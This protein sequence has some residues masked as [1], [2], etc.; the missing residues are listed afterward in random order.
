MNAAAAFA[1]RATLALAMPA[2]VRFQRALRDP[3]PVQAAIWQRILRRNAGTDFGTIHDFANIRSLDE[4]RQCV[5]LRDYDEYESWIRQ[6]EAGIENVLTAEPVRFLEPTGGSS[7]PSKKIPY[8]GQLM[9]EFSAATVPWSADLLLHRPRLRNGRAYWAVS[10]PVAEGM[11]HERDTFPAA[12]RWLLGHTVVGPSRGALAAEPHRWREATLRLLLEA[13]D[14]AFIS[15]W[16]PS[17]LTLL[18]EGM[19]AEDTASRW[20]QLDLISCWT[21]ATSARPLE[22]MRRRFPHVEVQGKGL[23][24][25]EGIV[26]VPF[27][28]VPAPAAAVT[29]H[30]LEFLDGVNSYLVHELEVGKQYEVV[31]TTGGGLYRYRLR[32]LVRVEGYLHR[33]PLLRFTGRADGVID[34]AGEK[35]SPAFV[36][37]ALARAAS[38]LQ[39]SIGFAMLAPAAE[40]PPGYILYADRPHEGRR[41]AAQLE[42]ELRQSH[43]YNLCRTLGQLAPVRAVA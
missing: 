41:L 15:V 33:T 1:N 18:V 43:H 22:R 9:A 23:L 21:D 27:L 12:I 5:P 24:A 34:L 16:S 19:E 37:Q 31:L 32:D 2:W 13:R 11:A 14:L 29:S 20:P 30:F 6:I 26:S 38:A 28:G 40:E 7:G 4:W 8:T 39:L 10:P 36:E 42:A 3:A 25:T 35:L 17:F